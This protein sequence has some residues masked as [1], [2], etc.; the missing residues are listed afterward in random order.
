MG[1]HPTEF[2]LVNGKNEVFC[3]LDLKYHKDESWAVIAGE[4][5]VCSDPYEEIPERIHP[6]PA[7]L[8]RTGGALHGTAPPLRSV[9]LDARLFFKITRY[10]PLGKFGFISS[11]KLSSLPRFGARCRSGRIP[12]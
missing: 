9:V 1:H 2:Y 7:E 11:P 12:Y 8:G 3:A 10:S 6:P 5:L 4:H